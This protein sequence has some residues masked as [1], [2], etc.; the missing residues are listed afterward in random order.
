MTQSLLYIQHYKNPEHS[1]WEHVR[2]EEVCTYLQLAH[3]T[4]VETNVLIKQMWVQF[5]YLSTHTNGYTKCLLRVYIDAHRVS[6]NDLHICAQ[7]I[8]NTCKG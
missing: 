4:H 6:V 8:I 2:T 1:Q 3:S 5:V 7:N